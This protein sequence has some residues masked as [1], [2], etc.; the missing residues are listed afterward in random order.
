[1][2]YLDLFRCLAQHDVRYL[3][4]GGLAMNLLGVPRL[5]MDIDL[6]LALDDA[7]L[8]AFI[9]CAR[10]LRLRPQIP[11]PLEAL[12]D[13]ERRRAWSEEKR[14]IAFALLGATPQVPVVDVLL[15][16][17]LDFDAAFGRAELRDAEG[18]TVRVASVQDMISLKRSA[19]RQQDIADVEHLARI[20]AQ[21]G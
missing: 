6:L 20:Q 10:A 4:V 3:L 9:Q 14:L 19:G 2:F 17:P 18:V 11:E 5:T 8:D 7:N 16:H 12:K 1:M 15:Q 13:P 21:R